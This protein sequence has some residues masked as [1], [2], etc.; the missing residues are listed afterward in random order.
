MLEYLLEV[1]KGKDDLNMNDINIGEKI[2]EFRKAKNLSI[3]ELANLS[4]VTPSLLS[5]IERGLSN[6]SINS[7]KLISKALDIPIF[8]FFLEPVNTKNLIVRADKRK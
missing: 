4:Q 7:L 5:Q 1:L 6:P 8:H 2:A 3:R